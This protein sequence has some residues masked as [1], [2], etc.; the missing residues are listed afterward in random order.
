MPSLAMRHMRY[1]KYQIITILQDSLYF[2]ILLL[3]ELHQITS[4][5]H[6]SKMLKPLWLLDLEAISYKI[7]R[8]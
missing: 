3:Q 2:S 7:T 5:L 1:N 6:L 8:F 4:K